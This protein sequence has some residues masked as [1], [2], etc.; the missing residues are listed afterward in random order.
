[1]K[2]R[3]NLHAAFTAVCVCISLVGYYRYGSVPLLELTLGLA[4]SRAA[5]S[6]HPEPRQLLGS[7]ARPANA[8]QSL[9]NCS[10][11]APSD[12]NDTSEAAAEPGFIG[13]HH[14]VENVISLQHLKK[15]I[16]FSK[17][18]GLSYLDHTGLNRFYL[19]SPKAG[20]IASEVSSSKQCRERTFLDRKSP[21]VGLVSAPG[22]GNTW[23]RHLLEQ[24][25]GIFTGS[26]YCDSSLKAIFPG[27][28]IGMFKT[29]SED[30]ILVCKLWHIIIIIRI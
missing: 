2:A 30:Y 8:S 25:T 7:P 6:H 10:S 15:K 21:I 28:Y 29:S 14:A 20:P 27:E 3:N 16:S 23:L 24:A 12:A 18:K 13:A 19:C 9:C 1:M 26:V 5:S 17:H 11:L 22:S 4:S